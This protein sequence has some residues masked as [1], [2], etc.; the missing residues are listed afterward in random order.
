METALGNTARDGWSVSQRHHGFREGRVVDREAKE[1]EGERTEV[2]AAEKSKDAARGM[3]RA[4]ARSLE[5]CDAEGLSDGPQKG[6]SR[7]IARRP[8]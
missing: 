8:M 7:A 6:A 4:A 1:A 2:P 5:K 3:S